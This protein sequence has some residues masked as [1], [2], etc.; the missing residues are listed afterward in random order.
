[1]TLS[2]SAFDLTNGFNILRLTC[3][4][5]FIPH[6]YA[7][8]FVPAALEVFVKGGFK[9]PAFWLYTSAAVEIALAVGLIFAI[10]T[11][12]VA[13]IAALHLSVAAISV[14]R[15]S[16]RKWLWNIGGCEFPVFW[17]ICCIVIAISG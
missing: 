1:M 2:Y 9:P 15:V 3:G 10:F 11:T 6:I 14:Y 13:L 17:A 5:L 4:A 8:F 7:G 12:F 16:G